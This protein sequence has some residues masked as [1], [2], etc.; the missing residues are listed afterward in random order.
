MAII[1]GQKL[2]RRRLVLLPP[3]A[4]TPA[5]ARAL[6]VPAECPPA[7][8]AVLVEISRRVALGRGGALPAP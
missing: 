7:L 2:R 4:H 5:Q 1:E 6:A 8:L 3:I